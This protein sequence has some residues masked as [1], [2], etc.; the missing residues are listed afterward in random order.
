MLKLL[1]KNPQKDILQRIEELCRNKKFKYLIE[2]IQRPNLVSVGLI[3]TGH[4]SGIFF[5]GSIISEQNGT[6]LVGDFV[7]TDYAENVQK[8]KPVGDIIAIGMFVTAVILVLGVIGFI[9]WL[10]LYFLTNMQWWLT[11]II[12]FLAIFTP[13]IFLHIKTIINMKKNRVTFQRKVENSK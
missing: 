2:P 10:P 6:F 13:V 7:D 12:I 5:K 11:A 3:K 9:L 1:I 8:R 4:S